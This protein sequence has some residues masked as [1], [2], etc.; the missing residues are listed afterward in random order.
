MLRSD[1]SRKKAKVLL[2]LGEQVLDCV[3]IDWIRNF[4]SCLAAGSS[5]SQRIGYAEGRN[6]A[7]EYR[8]A[9]GRYDPLPAQL[10]DLTQRKVGVIVFIGIPA[11]EELVHQ[12]RDSPIPIVMTHGGDP[13]RVGLVA[14]MN[15]PGGNAT[16]VSCERRSESA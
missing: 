5:G 8:F 3:G 11:I 16:G 4:Q 12:V 10:T 14:S 7:I 9:D 15:R 6:V 2:C 1:G 13:V